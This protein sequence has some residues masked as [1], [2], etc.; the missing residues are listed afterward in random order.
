MGGERVD[1]SWTSLQQAA[2]D[3]D[4]VAH[5]L[6]RELRFVQDEL[7][8]YGEP[9]GGDEL[10]MLIGVTHEVV[11]ELAFDKLG[12]LQEDLA[13]HAEAL[14]GVARTYR[15]NEA[16]GQELLERTSRNLDGN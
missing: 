16:H 6:G 10:G 9:W 14:D 13:S 4:K 1:V 8:G 15:D 5:R 12:E 7:A 3:L 11:S 2:D